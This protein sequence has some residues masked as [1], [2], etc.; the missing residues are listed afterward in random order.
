MFFLFSASTGSDDPHGGVGRHKPPATDN[1]GSAR[2]SSFRMRTFPQEFGVNPPRVA[3]FPARKALIRHCERSEAIQRNVE[4][5]IRPLDCFVAALL[6][7]DG[8]RKPNGVMPSRLD[9][10]LVRP[11]AKHAV[12]RFGLRHRHRRDAL[13]IAATCGKRD[14]FCARPRSAPAPD[15]GIRPSRSRAGRTNGRVPAS[16]PCHGRL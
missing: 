5:P 4:R 15:S 3:A 12:T 10:L 2:I 8:A 6:A 16:N 9:L 1:A 7:T 11:P 13:V 14:R